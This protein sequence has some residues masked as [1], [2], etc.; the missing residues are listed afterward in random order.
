MEDNHC[1]IKGL[2][3][4]NQMIEKVPMTS[5]CLFPLR[6]IPYMKGK[7]NSKDTFKEERTE[8]KKHYDK[9]END[10]VDIQATFK[11]EVHGEYR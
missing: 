3:L 9:E 4:S 8:A 7:E 2:R 5:N 10:S 6:I 11:S 1:V